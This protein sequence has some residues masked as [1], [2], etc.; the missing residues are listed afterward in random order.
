[1]QGIM[2]VRKINAVFYRLIFLMFPALI[3]VYRES[4]KEIFDIAV[5]CHRSGYFYIVSLA[6]AVQV[7]TQT[8]AAI[9]RYQI[10]IRYLKDKKINSS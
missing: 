1:M 9:E 3:R 5:S 8:R 10:Y 2:Y 7:Y 4:F 6:N